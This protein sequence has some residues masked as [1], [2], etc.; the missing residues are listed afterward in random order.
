[1]SVFLR[2]A[3]VHIL[4]AAERAD[5]AQNRPLRPSANF[6]FHTQCDGIIMPKQMTPGMLFAPRASFFA[7]FTMF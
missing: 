4:V 7:V 2:A 1:M 3:S 5:H 6:A